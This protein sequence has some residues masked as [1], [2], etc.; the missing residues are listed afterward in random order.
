[1]L[2][3]IWVAFL[4]MYIVINYIISFLFFKKFFRGDF[5]NIFLPGLGSLVSLPGAGGDPEEE[6]G[7]AR[8]TTHPPIH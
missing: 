2:A 7:G 1:M 5:V 8:P 3:K 4:I 6:P